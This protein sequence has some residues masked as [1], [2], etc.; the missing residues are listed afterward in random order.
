MVVSKLSIQGRWRLTVTEEG[1]GLG[2]SLP[3]K[4][5]R[6]LIEGSTNADGIHPG[7]V[8]YS[9]EVL[10]N[11]EEPW[12]LTVHHLKAEGQWSDSTSRDTQ[13]IITG[14]QVTYRIEAEDED[15]NIVTGTADFDDLVLRADKIGMIDIPIRPYAVRMNTLDTMPDGIFESALGTHYMAVRVQ[16]VWTQTL[17]TSQ[18]PDG[19][20][21]FLTTESLVSLGISST[22]R[23]VLAAGGIQVVDT[24]TTEELQMLGQEMSGNRVLLGSL[25]PWERRTVY[26]K[27]D[28]SQAQ[29]RKHDVTFEVVQTNMPDKGHPNRRASHNIFVSRS[30]FNSVTNE[31]FSECD[32]GTLFLTLKKVAVEYTTLRDAV[33][34]ARRQRADHG[35]PLEHRA[36]KIL[37]DLLD[38]RR[39]DLCELKSLLDCA[40]HG[41][42]G[43][44]GTNSNG[45]WPCDDIIMFPTDFSYRVVPRE[46][47]T[48][49]LGPLPYDD[50]IWKAFLLLL[51]LLLTVLTGQSAAADIAFGSDDVVIGTLFSSKREEETAGPHEG[52]FLVDAALCE[53]NGNRELPVATS[54]PPI[55]LLDVQ[56]NEDFK[57]SIQSVDGHIQLSGETF[58]NDELD[59]MIAENCVKP[60]DLDA[61]KE[62]RV[63]KSGARTGITHGIMTCIEPCM[64]S[65]GLDGVFRQY[66]SQ[67]RIEQISTSDLPES[68]QEAAL[69]PVS[70]SGDSGS[71]W[72]H[73]QTGKIVALHHSGADDDT[74]GHGTRIRDVM[75]KMNIRFTEE[76]EGE[77]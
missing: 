43:K 3:A 40:C 19:G 28:C 71:I 2:T 59:E 6:F 14:S 34:C 72:V 30:G 35:D 48:G 76:P 65:E 67:L 7:T 70:R 52:K 69:Q 63:Y 39:V 8:G 23:T 25:E 27:L 55:Q 41:Q 21:P 26:F 58:T 4:G 33:I 62:L 75:D 18:A 5:H 73:L 42:G 24:W 9:V 56:S 49:Q 57:A 20:G 77:N 61:I 11:G 60:D 50:P 13:R 17:P 1:G 15:P 10:S 66:S 38:G 47:Y 16:N 31:F 36:R 74:S 45:G 32:Q 22:G 46:P 64:T 44:S 37:K 12:N 53:L 29:P 54:G 51:A 68:E